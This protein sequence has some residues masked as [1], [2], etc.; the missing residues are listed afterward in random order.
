MRVS[1]DDRKEQLIAATM[2]LMR[3][4]GVQAVTMRAIAKD[5]SMSV[6]PLLL[7]LLMR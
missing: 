2:E 5:S 1:A 6:K 7:L 4:E 3:R